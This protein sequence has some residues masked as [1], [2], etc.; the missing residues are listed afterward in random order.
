MIGPV[1]VSV[2]DKRNSYK[3][4]LKRNITILCG[5]SG[6]GK[7]TLFEMVADY[8]HFGK[9]SSV[10]ISCD[11]EVIAV[12]GTDWRQIIEKV[13]D[14]IIIIDE[15]NEFIR[16]KEFAKAIQKTS[17]YYLLITRGYLEQLPISVD[18]IYEISGEKNKKFTRVYKEVDH[19]YDA[20]AKARLPFVPDVIITEDSKTGYQFFRTISDRSGI[21]CIPAAGKSNVYELLTHYKEKNVL[22]I[23][24]GAAFGSNIENIVK[25]QALYPNKIGIFLPES[26]E[27]LIL[28]AGIVN[29]YNLEKL[30][31]PEQYIDSKK[32]FSWERYF[33]D[34]LVEITKDL[35][36]KK[37]PQNK[38]TLPAFY[39]KESSAEK[40]K[41]VMPGIRI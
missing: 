18:E 31:V 20:P 22:V 41:A 16:T 9:N 30:T 12:I 17:N 8:N 19:M 6:R 13:Y 36:Y 33:T 15:D 2:R 5:D 25:R 21:E 24:D 4:T 1:D 34:L 27:W 35:T 10:K 40:V 38:R 32:Y 39:L 37:Y 3:F 14:S 23:A 26:F 7:T 28:L 11:R 29:D